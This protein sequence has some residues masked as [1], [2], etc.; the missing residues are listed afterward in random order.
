[1]A[2]R[3]DEAH[4]KRHLFAT[5]VK[6]G[7]STNVFICLRSK[8]KEYLFAKIGYC[9]SEDG[10]WVSSVQVRLV[11]LSRGSGQALAKQA[12]TGMIREIYCG[13]SG[14]KIHLDGLMQVRYWF[15]AVEL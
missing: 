8:E 1:M 15:T 10:K 3:T 5:A 7:H 14:A 12:W 4:L 2:R 11:C 9:R 13:M 6:D